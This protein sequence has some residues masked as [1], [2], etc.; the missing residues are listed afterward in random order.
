MFR[1]DQSYEEFETKS[2]KAL[3]V[4]GAAAGISPWRKSREK[5][6]TASTLPGTVHDT[7][8]GSATPWKTG[9]G[10]RRFISQ[11]T[12]LSHTLPANMN[13]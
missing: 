10:S 6:G 8:H 2:E 1:K 12:A 11:L 5:R 3:T 4:V 7:A 13:R 9:C